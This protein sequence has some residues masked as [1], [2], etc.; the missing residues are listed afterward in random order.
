M[1]SEYRELSRSESPRNDPEKEWVRRG[2]DEKGRE[3]EVWDN[4]Q[5]YSLAPGDATARRTPEIQ[6]AQ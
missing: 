2:F 3:E 1:Q 6:A 4:V 5:D